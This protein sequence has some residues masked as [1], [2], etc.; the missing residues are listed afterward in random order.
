MQSYWA[1]LKNLTIGFRWC[2]ILFGNMANHQ[3]LRRC[4]FEKYPEPIF[5]S[6]MNRIIPK[7]SDW[8]RFRRNRICSWRPSW[9]I[10]AIEPVTEVGHSRRVIMSPN[11]IRICNPESGCDKSDQNY[12]LKCIFIYETLRSELD[13]GIKQL[14]YFRF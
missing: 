5:S 7:F 3:L 11:V 12:F 1:R 13:F 14:K 6:R 8:S 9:V 2:I 4:K 10:R